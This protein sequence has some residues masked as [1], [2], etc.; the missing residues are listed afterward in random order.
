M[1]IFGV[2]DSDDLRRLATAA[3]V[4]LDWSQPTW[5]LVGLVNDHGLVVA[6]GPDEEYLRMASRLAVRNVDPDYRGYTPWG[7]I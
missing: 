6:A 4:V 7:A 2:R 1:T 3:G 5:V